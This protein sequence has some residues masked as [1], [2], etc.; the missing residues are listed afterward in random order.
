MTLAIRDASTHTGGSLSQ[1]VA[2]SAQSTEKS[3]GLIVE[4]IDRLGWQPPSTDTRKPT[5]P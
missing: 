4:A 5:Q 1:A 3:S 2:V